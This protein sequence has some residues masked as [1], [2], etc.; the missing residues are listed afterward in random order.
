M[1]DA[2]ILYTAVCCCRRQHRENTPLRGNAFR[3]STSIRQ[4][5]GA[6]RARLLVTRAD[7]V[8]AAPLL[9]GNSTPGEF[10]DL[11]GVP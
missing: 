7:C 3:A 8:A 6:I 4:A 1:T 5:A 9:T 10:R 2:L 11:A